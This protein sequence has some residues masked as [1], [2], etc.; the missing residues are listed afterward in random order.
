MQ[1]CEY[2]SGYKYGRVLNIPG[3][4]VCQ[5]FAYASIIQ[6]S[7]YNWIWLNNP[8]WQGSEYARSMF[9]RVLDKPPV[10][11]MPGLRIC[12]GYE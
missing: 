8:L 9:H 1:G 4:Q 2:V 5:V 12:Q 10:L 7:E 3:F 11:N 6:G